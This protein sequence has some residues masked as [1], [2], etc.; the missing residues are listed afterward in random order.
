MQNVYTPKSGR[1]PHQSPV[2]EVR[3]RD[4]IIYIYQQWEE[5]I[6]SYERDSNQRAT[7]DITASV[8][9]TNTTGAIQTQL[10]LNAGTTDSYQQVRCTILNYVRAQRQFGPTPKDIGQVGK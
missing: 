1:N 8:L 10:Q 6:H 2:D 9:M 5:Y 7:D 4:L 3:H